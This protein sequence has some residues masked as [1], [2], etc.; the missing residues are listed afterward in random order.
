MPL[1]SLKFGKVAIYAIF[2]H[3]VCVTTHYREVIMDE[4]SFTLI[5]MAHGIH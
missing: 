4:E 3:A 5:L 2:I 1:H